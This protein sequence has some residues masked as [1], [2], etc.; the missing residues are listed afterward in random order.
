MISIGCFYTGNRKL[1]R[2]PEILCWLPTTTDTIFTRTDQRLVEHEA[3]QTI[4]FAQTWVQDLAG[5]SQATA[6]AGSS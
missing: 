6:S 4:T 5:D 3:S 2:Q 1:A